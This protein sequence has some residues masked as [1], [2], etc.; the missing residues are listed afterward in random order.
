[1]TFNNERAE[2]IDGSNF[3]ITTSGKVFKETGVEKKP[4][5]RN[6]DGY[7][8]V[9][10][11]V[12]NYWRT[13]L[14]H[15]LVA[16]TFIGKPKDRVAVHHKDGNKQNNDVS[17]LEYIPANTTSQ[18]HKTVGIDCIAKRGSEVHK[19]HSMVALHKFLVKQ[20]Y[21]NS[22][23]TMVYNLHRDNEIMGYN[24]EKGEFTYSR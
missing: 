21:S 18:Y 15:T 17:N 24:I 19:F 11:K 12:G 6:V 4:Y 1:M 14:I 2:R 22:Y 7:S 9:K 3:Y 5:I 16:S 20:G 13:Y 10:V 8:A 23:Y